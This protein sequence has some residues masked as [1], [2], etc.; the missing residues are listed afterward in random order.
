V[1]NAVYLGYLEQA[2]IDHATAVGWPAS[3]LR[4]EAGAVFVARRHDIEFL[5]PAFEGDVLEILTWP[6]GMSGARAWRAYRVRRTG[7]DP[8]VLP[9]AHLID[10]GAIPEPSRNELVV[11]ARTEWAFAHVV[12]GRPVRIPDAVFADFL[13]E[14]G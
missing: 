12:R 1:N 8:G 13:V 5:Q 9:A 10:G 7:G 6:E 2:A 11:S 3:R 14:E 4:D